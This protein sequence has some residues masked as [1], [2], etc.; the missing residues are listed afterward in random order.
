LIIKEKGRFGTMKENTKTLMTF[1]DF[2]VAFRGRDDL[3][4]TLRRPTHANA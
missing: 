4:G 2:G 1:R 3:A